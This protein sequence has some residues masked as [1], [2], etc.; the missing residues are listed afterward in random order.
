MTV[1]RRRGKKWQQLDFGP[2][3]IYT[4]KLLPSFELILDSR[5]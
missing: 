2:N 1:Y 4:T 5:S 3:D